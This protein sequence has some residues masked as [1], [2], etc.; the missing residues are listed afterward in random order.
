MEN[1]CNCTNSLALFGEPRGSLRQVYFQSQSLTRARDPAVYPISQIKPL[2]SSSSSS[3]FSSLQSILREST[4]LRY[5][6]SYH[7]PILAFDSFH[8]EPPRKI[9]PHAVRPTSFSLFFLLT[10]SFTK[11]FFNP[12][13]PVH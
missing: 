7:L 3:S 1:V 8:F 13:L 2:A 11:H 6:N 5:L 12:S 4:L 10:R 9:K